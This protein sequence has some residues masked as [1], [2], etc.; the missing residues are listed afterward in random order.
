MEEMVGEEKG[1]G[2]RSVG[3]GNTLKSEG[4][5][6]LRTPS[7]NDVQLP[8]ALEDA[9]PIMHC[10]NSL[11]TCK[12]ALSLVRNARHVRKLVAFRGSC[13]LEVPFSGPCSS[14][15]AQEGPCAV[16]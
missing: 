16:T 10:A 6:R 15:C 13:V 4:Q 11:I 12:V 7:A 9:E 8:I 14:F 5:A 2:G 1:E 3:G